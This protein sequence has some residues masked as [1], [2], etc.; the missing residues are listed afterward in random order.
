MTREWPELI[1]AI[2]VSQSGTKAAS[3]NIT[4]RDKVADST[5][6]LCAREARDYGAR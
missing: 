4:P 2:L 5:L 3:Q 6:K 1:P